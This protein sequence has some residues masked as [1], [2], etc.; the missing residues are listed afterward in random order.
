MLVSVSTIVAW[1]TDR[2]E[3]ERP[4]G[5]EPESQPIVTVVRVRL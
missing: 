2:K 3:R 4:G 5:K 1:S